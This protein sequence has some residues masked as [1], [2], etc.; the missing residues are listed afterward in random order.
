MKENLSLV[1]SA[2][3]LNS[4]VLEVTVCGVSSWL[5][6][7]TVVPAFTVS[8]CGLKLNW[9][10]TM[11]A[12]CAEEASKLAAASV[13]AMTSLLL[14]G[15]LMSKISSLKLAAARPLSRAVAGLV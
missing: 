10:I 3:D 15:V 11:S 8:R 6:Q 13:T 2:F 5:I 9:S 7:V 14:V 4:G 12:A 1:S